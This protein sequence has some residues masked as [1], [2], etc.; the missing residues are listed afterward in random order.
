MTKHASYSSSTFLRGRISGQGAIDERPTM[1]PS[2]S[3]A[4][5]DT[6]IQL[7]RVAEPAPPPTSWQSYQSVYNSLARPKRRH[8]IR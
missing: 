7:L 2:A 1:Y 6:I 4:E 3:K 8:P 5:L